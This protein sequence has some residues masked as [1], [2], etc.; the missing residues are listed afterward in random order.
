MQKNHTPRR[1]TDLQQTFL[2]S[3]FR[4]PPQTKVTLL[5]V[6]ST[7]KFRQSVR[8]IDSGKGRAKKSPA[9]AGLFDQTKG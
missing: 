2:L 5:A 6:Y 8:A 7:L 4:L 9:F 3:L 1:G